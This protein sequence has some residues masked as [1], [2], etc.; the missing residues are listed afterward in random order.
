MDG[1]D[2]FA[3]RKGMS[4][5]H[6][7]YICALFSLFN[8]SLC[9]HTHKH[10]KLLIKPLIVV[11]KGVTCYFMLHAKEKLGCTIHKNAV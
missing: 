3:N 9:A 1:F 6:L 7:L 8:L 11:R 5:N 4:N 10:I 2:W